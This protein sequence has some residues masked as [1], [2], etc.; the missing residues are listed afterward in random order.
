MKRKTLLLSTFI[1]GIIIL[2]MASYSMTISFYLGKVKLIRGGKAIKMKKGLSVGNGDIIKTGKGSIVEL[3][4]T[5]N[6]KVSIKPHTTVKI[7]SKHVE[8]SEGVSVVSGRIVGKFVKLKKG[9]HKLYTPTTVAGVRGTKFQ[10]AVSR[11]GDS[12]ID[13]YKGRLAIDN[14]KG[15]VDLKPGYSTEARVSD[16]P[17]K[18]RTRGSISRWQKKQN[19]YVAKNMDKQADRYVQQIDS[20]ENDAEASEDSL[21]ELEDDVESMKSK[22]DLKKSEKNISKA[23]DK[24]ENNMMMNEA[25]QMSMENLARDYEGKDV[26]KKLKKIVEKS[27]DVREMQEKNYNAIQEVKAKYREAY[28]KIMGKYKEDRSKIHDNFKNMKDKILHPNS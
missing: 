2:P 22:E 6:S 19:R 5:D 10:I 11:G 26:S 21:D 1:A 13:L 24:I 20:W 4:Y 17:I 14:N 23:E 7:G 25:S 9:R 8:G 27:N 18:K 12:K 28:D 15:S 16:A 3:K